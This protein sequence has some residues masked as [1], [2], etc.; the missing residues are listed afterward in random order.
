MDT[1]FIDSVE[2]DYSKKRPE[3][4]VG[5][6]VRLHTKL[7]DK[8]K[9][10]IQTFEG[11]VISIK[12]RGLG[13]TLTVRRIASGVGVEKIVPLHSPKIEKIE[14]LERGKVR[15]AKLY[16][17]RK[18]IGKRAMD[19]SKAE[20]IYLVDEK[21]VKSE[22]SKEIQNLESKIQNEADSKEKKDGEEEKPKGKQKEESK[23]ETKTEKKE[24]EKGH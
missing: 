23:D 24:E 12:G 20:A 18:K 3:I 2:K 5:D 19:V 10:R 1:N 22:E 4:R 7:K 9:E 8:D 21:E 15:R 11:V 16:Y 14:V 6:T 17:M 13:K